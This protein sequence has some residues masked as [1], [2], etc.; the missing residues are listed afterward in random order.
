MLKQDAREMYN[1]RKVISSDDNAFKYLPNRLVV[2]DPYTPQEG[3]YLTFEF[4]NWIP[5][6]MDKIYLKYGFV[7]RS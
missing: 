5:Y 3:F 7:K 1:K 6:S 4:I 2:T